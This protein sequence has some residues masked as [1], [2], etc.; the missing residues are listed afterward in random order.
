MRPEDPEAPRRGPT[1]RDAGRPWIELDAALERPVWREGEERREA[2]GLVDEPASFDR[3]SFLALAGLSA[4]LAACERLPV[5]HALPYLVAPEEITP[6]VSTHYA[7]TCLACPAACGLVAT[8]RDGRPV[9]LEGH[10][11][12]P[13]S[14][15]GLCALG[16]ADLRALYDA[17]R[18]RGAALGG[19][20]A[21]WD[22]TDAA[23]R[24]G[25]TEAK[26]AGKAVYVLSRTLTSPALRA[27]VAA[28]CG[29]WGGRLVEAD[30]D[31]EP[32]SAVLE[33]YEALHGRPLA[34]ALEIGAADLLVTLG[35]DLLGAGADPVTHTAAWSA[36]RRDGS[37]PPL[38]HVH[39]EGSLSL[40]GANA[41][42]RWL[43]TGE[44]RRRIALWLLRHVAARTPGAE[45]EALGRALGSLPALGEH[46]TH[47]EAL[48]GELDTARGRSLIVT[49]TDDR[50]EALAVA[51]ANR[52]LGN[53]GR[54]LD[55]ARPSLGRRGLDRE[56]AR[57][58]G[59][60]A[61]GEVGAI[62]VLG[63]D[64]VD[65]LPDGEAFAAAL[66]RMPLS[67]AVTDRP[68]ATAAACR[69]VAAAHH[70][71]ECWGDA[72][73]RP[74]VLTLAQPLVRPLFDTRAPMTSLLL[75]AGAP[76][77]DDRLFL[78]ERFRHEVL[79][80]ADTGGVEAAWRAAVS[81]GMAPHDASV[82]RSL[83]AAGEPGDAAAALRTALEAAHEA[84]TPGFEAD[85]V[86]EVAL[87]DG[88]RAHV[89]WL[90]ELPDPLTRVAWTP[91]ARLAPEAA[92]SLGVRDG[93]VVAVSVGERRVELPARVLPGQHPRVVGVPV[94]YGRVDG[95]GA[96][97]NANAFRLARLDA[98]GRA[99]RR[100][101]PAR[102]ERTGRRERLP[103]VQPH[104]SAEGRPV[105]FQVSAPDEHV[106]GAHVPAG[107]DLW[108]E[109]ERGAPQWHMTIDLDCCTGCSAC[110]VACQAENNVAVVG[111]DEMARNR[112]MHWIRI[113]RYFAG[114]PAQPD[115]L[116]EPMMCGQCH[117]APCE[118][119]CPVA[120]T[121]HSEDG[122][123]QQVYNRCVGTRYCANNCPYKVRAFNW[124]DNQPTDP[125]ERMVLNPD[126]V[127]RARGV[128]EKCSFCVQRIQA[129]RI[130]A[131]AEG[132]PEV[133]EVETACQQSCPARAIRFGDGADPEVASRHAD[134]RAFRVLADLGVGPR[135]T[136]LARVRT[137]QGGHS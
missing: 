44:D 32:Q 45:A 77:T 51:L 128:M 60:L 65:Q 86:A 95:D 52:L 88:S 8:V 1:T 85:L 70:P 131:R 102:V 119:V 80:A 93:D 30:P 101:L 62:V 16:Q 120:A 57:L 22:E 75:W 135:I 26:R 82:T 3:R 46:I 53:E 103:L 11:E 6:G 74:G 136:Y 29:T 59:A 17:G 73:P 127:V 48:A 13:L 83:A 49:A 100:G 115:V 71:L 12:H 87:R 111:P 41:D 34:P 2:P 110:V 15:G 133:P 28:F 132:R 96:R 7:S 69:V 33:A 94:G 84:E 108:P 61:A 125:V 121:V 137:R 72:E 38:R 109:R 76:T 113:D 37:R 78:K 98:D 42:E 56:V 23:V 18:L 47:L 27:A 68:T 106:H 24:A 129:A 55:L 105:V 43:A 19:R 64:P 63:L 31:A 14:R 89:P 107:R 118:T 134:P 79:R 66:A 92:R 124:F 39:V 21:G 114:D 112:G 35:T 20:A 36:R 130:A 54:T 5:R 10:R 90:R 9:K 122:L 97:A 117:H 4:S 104:P 25:L 91:C 40:T 99:A 116:F 50:A 81:R 67:V 126:V 58:R 123:N